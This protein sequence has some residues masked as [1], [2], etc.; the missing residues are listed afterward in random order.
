MNQDMRSEKMSFSFSYVIIGRAFL[1]QLRILCTQCSA[2]TLKVPGFQLVSFTIYG[3][4]KSYIITL[5]TYVQELPFFPS[6][7][8][9]IICYDWFTFT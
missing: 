5:G 6:T 1:E 7:V 4:A 3:C 9:P 8:E 2:R